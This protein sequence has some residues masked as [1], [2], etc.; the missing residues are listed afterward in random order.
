MLTSE[1]LGAWEEK[2]FGVGNVALEPDN[3]WWQTSI[4]LGIL[5]QGIHQGHCL[6]DGEGPSAELS[7]PSH[8]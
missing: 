6:G 2:L 4:I 3:C 1:P 7:C 5:C 8:L